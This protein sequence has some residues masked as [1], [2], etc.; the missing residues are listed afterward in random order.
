MVGVILSTA[1]KLALKI[2]S[3]GVMHLVVA[4]LVAF[5]ITRDWR[6]ALAVGMV[7]PFF[8]TI[9]YSIHDRVWH[10][11]ERRRMASNI[12]E[13]AEA[14]TARL[15]IMSPDEQTRVHDHHGHSHALP[16]S[17]KQ[18]AV[19]TVTYGVMHFTV[20]VA[21]AFA[22]TQDIRTA[23][24]IGMIEPLVQTVF[25]TLHD[26]IWSRIEERRARTRPATA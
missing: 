13:A 20:A 26:R 22:L 2:A 17:F 25:F 24:A 10:R 4:I 5:A 6:I 12:E 3:Y 19:K 7:E 23:L 16:R 21:V 14:F 9:A 1:R 18:V 11:I 8:Q 15:D